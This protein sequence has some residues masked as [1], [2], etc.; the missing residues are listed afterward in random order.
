M[1]QGRGLPPTEPCRGRGG[2][3]SPFPPCDHPFGCRPQHQAPQRVSGGPQE[4]VAIRVSSAAQ[5]WGVPEGHRAGPAAPTAAGARK[6]VKG[7]V[8]E[9]STDA[10]GCRWRLLVLGSLWEGFRV[11]DSAHRH[12]GV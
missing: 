12:H 1:A 6:Q 11:C 10:R 2:C 3:P 8:L 9:L 4:E 7:S 5:F